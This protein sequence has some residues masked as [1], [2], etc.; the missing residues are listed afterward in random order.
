MKQKI[1][2]I[3]IGIYM[4]FELL[5]G[6]IVVYSWI[7]F[8]GGM[9]PVG[10]GPS[11]GEITFFVQSNGVHTD[12]CLPIESDQMDWSAVIP[13]SDFPKV[14]DPKFISIGWGDKGFFLDTPEWS[15]LTMST[16][17]NAAFF[18]S[19]TAMHV[20]YMQS[21]PVESD[22]VAKVQITNENYQHLIDYI[23]E[24][25]DRNENGV[26]LIANR[27]YWLHDNFYEA[28]GNYH[29]FNTC[30]AWTNRALKL[31]G[32]RTGL[33]SLSADGIMRHLVKE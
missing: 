28:K 11:S 30:N 9:I 23:L 20:A 33:F 32:V 14:Q 10:K 4:L 27:G 6:F 24:S 5:I 17:L 12:V 31:S 8:F 25:F 2:A 26:Q 1:K 21:I 29:L 7:F 13:L 15:D 18:K 3:R 16:A 19:G 22:R